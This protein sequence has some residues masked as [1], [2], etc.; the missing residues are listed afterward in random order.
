MC[1]GVRG[2]ARLTGPRSRAIARTSW[3][4]RRPAARGHARAARR[5]RHHRESCARGTVRAARGEREARLGRLG[6]LC[7]GGWEV[8]ARDGH[9]GA[10]L[11]R[12]R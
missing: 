5:R 6:E 10:Q 1:P 2:S 11:R 12:V 8:R 4:G 3:R 7:A 9:G